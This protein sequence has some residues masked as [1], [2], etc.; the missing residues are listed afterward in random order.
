MAAGIL[1]ALAFASAVPPRALGAPAPQGTG[2]LVSNRAAKPNEIG[3]RPADGAAVY[4]N[5]P[6]LTWL[7]EPGAQTY[8]VEWSP[9]ARFANAARA[10]HVPFNTYTHHTPLAPG[11]AFSIEPG[12]YIPGRFG[13][14][15]EDI[16][17]AT[18]A[19][20]EPVNRA[21]H[22]LAVVDG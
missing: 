10:D 18:D 1:L 6:S 20:P 17:V 9:D 14:R 8:A 21:V 12:I 13:A 3:Y 19:G 7:H 11:H 16:V 2:P 5:P 4:F 22:T 15:L